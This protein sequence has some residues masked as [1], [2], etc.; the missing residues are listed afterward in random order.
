M[1]DVERDDINRLPES[2]TVGGGICLGR[3]APE[4]RAEAEAC[5]A[6]DMNRFMVLVND[7]PN[8]RVRR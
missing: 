4:T 1:F 3:L 2:C 7:D 8:G 5:L 6:A